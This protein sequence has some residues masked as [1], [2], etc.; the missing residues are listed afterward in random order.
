MARFLGS[1]LTP[2]EFQIEVNNGVRSTTTN[3]TW[4]GTRTTNDFRLGS[5]DSTVTIITAAG[6]V[7][8]GSTT[9]SYQF[10]VSGSVSSTIDA[11]GSG[12]AYFLRS[13]G[14]VSTIGPLSSISVS[15]CTSGAVLASSG[16]YT[17]SDARIKK[18]FTELPGSVADGMLSVKPLLFRYKNQSKSTPLQLGYRAQDL[19]RAKLPHCVNFI[20]V[21]DLPVEDTDLDTHNIQ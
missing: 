18:D 6:R 5:N 20:D 3:A 12:V 14:L 1:N 15:I 19:L 7:G 11:A 10:Q 17:T 9:P 4:I 21:E 16:F 8:V 2:V 13:G